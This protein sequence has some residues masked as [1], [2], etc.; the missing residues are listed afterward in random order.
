MIRKLTFLAFFVSLF[1]SGFSQ[2]TLRVTSIPNSTPVGASIYVAGSFNGWNPN[3]TAYQL[4][5][6]NG[7]WSTT[8]AEGNGTH[9]FKFTRGSWTTVEGDSTGAFLPNRSLTFTGQPQTLTLSILSWEDLNNNPPQ[10]TAASNVSIM[11]NN[12]FMP[13]LNRNRK[14]WL[15]LPPDYHTSTKTYPVIYMQDG[16]NLFDNVTAFANEWEVDE[17]LNGLFNNG[18][19]GVI[20]VGIENSQYR[21]HEYSPWPI[22]NSNGNVFSN[23]EGKEYMRF[24]A[25]TLKPHVDANYRT[26]PQPPYNALIGSSMGGLISTFGGIEHADLFGKI[27]SFSPSY[28]MVEP[29]IYQYVDSTTSNLANTRIYHVSSAQ[30]NTQFGVGTKINTLVSHLTNKGVSA[31]N[32]FVKLDNYGQH[33]ETYWKGE[34][35]AAYQWL[36]ADVM[37]AEREY[38]RSSFFVFYP[39]P[40]SNSVFCKSSSD[41]SVTIYNSNGQK[42]SSHT[43]DK[44]GRIELGNLNS[45]LYILKVRGKG[46]NLNEKLLINP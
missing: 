8:I 19:Y 46:I 23:G 41:V 31:N 33:N 1:F 21:V 14:I 26:K 10:S 30:D 2:V 16:Q 3:D 25:E 9:G 18:D 12:F 40:A 4:V 39:N 45:G 35:A 29:T 44:F 38:E 7:I 32:T 5:E 13:Q 42:L 28:W 15:Y 22:I 17:T 27:G 20:V 34:F 6:N 11:S 24:I 37:L 36:F 43:I